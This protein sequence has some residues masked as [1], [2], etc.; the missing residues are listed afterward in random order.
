MFK[1]HL[2]MKP[3]KIGNGLFTNITI[4][5][6]SPILELTGNI[7]TWDKIVDKEHPAIIQISDNTYLGPSGDIDDYINHSCN[8]NCKI[9]IV[10]HRS[11]LYSIYVITANTE[12]TFD[13]S[14]TSTDSIDDWKMN[15]LCGDFNCRKLISGFQYLDNKIQESYRKNGILP[16]FMIH[17]IFMR[18]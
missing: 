5:A 3:S 4:P 8:P 9:Q 13:Y 6:N 11:I 18:K 17:K 10:G 16:L 14:T 7:S 2:S 15:C 1:Q 12:L